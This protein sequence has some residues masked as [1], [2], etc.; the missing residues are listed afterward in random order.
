MTMDLRLACAVGLLSGALTFA[1][2]PGRAGCGGRY[3][4]A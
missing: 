3:R 2:S 1:T 4:A